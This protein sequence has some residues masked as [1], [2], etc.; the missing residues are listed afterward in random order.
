MTSIEELSDWIKNGKQRAI[1][2][3]TM[4]YPMTGTEIL[5]ATLPYNPSILLGD[6]WWNIKQFTEKG[7]VE[8]MNP[9]DITGR[10]YTKT[11]IG[12]RVL[13][14]AFKIEIQPPS[15][16]VDWQRFAQVVRAKT[17]MT[18]FMEIAC[19][20]YF[21]KSIKTASNIRRLLK[22][23]EVPIALNTTIRSIKELSDINLI[24]CIGYADK[25][26]SKIYQTTDAGHQIYQEL[27]NR[28]QNNSSKKS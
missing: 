18:V 7:L 20:N 5:R 21:N 1:I 13:Y 25:Y 19:N 26:D 14:E 12:R 15:E 28:V 24:Q 4:I 3:K 9:S 10:L 17:R 22:K 8:C 11:I 27:R 16:K 2:A 23:R 6:I